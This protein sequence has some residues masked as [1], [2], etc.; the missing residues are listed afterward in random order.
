MEE[1][2][3]LATILGVV[4]GGLITWFFAWKYYKKAGDELLAESKK[5]KNASDLILW[6]LQNPEVKTGLIYNEKGEVSGITADM[7]AKL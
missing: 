6:K 2:T 5:L 4:L 1:E 7:S 3:V